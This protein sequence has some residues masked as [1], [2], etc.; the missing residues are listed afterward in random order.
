MSGENDPLILELVKQSAAFQVLLE[1]QGETLASITE[2]IAELKKEVNDDVRQLERLK[3]RGSG[4]LIG[5][6]IL[7]TSTA[8][9]FSESFVKFKHFIFG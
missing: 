7:A 3:N 4:I 8:T 5:L 9:I 6:G 2:D 1:K